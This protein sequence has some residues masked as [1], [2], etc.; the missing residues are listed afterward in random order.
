[1]PVKPF[2]VAPHLAA[3]TEHWFRFGAGGGDVSE[4]QDGFRGGR[5]SLGVL[6][7]RRRPVDRNA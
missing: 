4:P 7:A 1:M 3:A 6:T 2:V 5:A